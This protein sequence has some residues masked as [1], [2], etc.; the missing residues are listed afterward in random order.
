MNYSAIILAAGKGTRY[1]ETKQDVIF[2][3]KPLWKFSC[4]T[5]ASVVG[6]ERIVV[7]GKDIPGGKTRTQS[8]FNGLEALP[9]D[10]DRVIIV[11]AARPMVTKEQ[12]RE[13]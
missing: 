1:R 4:D 10:T 13:L 8:V 12:V 9:K 7:V 3:N 5:T 6:R 2:H 11:E